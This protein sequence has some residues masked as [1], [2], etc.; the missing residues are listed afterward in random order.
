MNCPESIDNTPLTSPKSFNNWARSLN[1]SASQ[2]FRP[3]TRGEI[4]EIFRRAEA[5]RRKVKVIGSLWSFTSS[6][7]SNDIVIESDNISG[8]IDPNLIIGRL[9][10]SDV[11][12]GLLDRGMLAHI[13]GGTKVCKINRM[14][15][16][17]SA[18]GNCGGEDEDNLECFTDSKAMPTLGG[19]GGQSIAGLIST[20][21]HGGDIFLRPIADN[22]LAIHLIGPGGQEWWI[23]RPLS[24][25]TGT[26]TDTQTELQNMA[27]SNTEISREICQHIRVKKDN[28]FFNAVLVSVG[29]MGFMYSLVI[30]VEDSFKLRETR[31]REI[32]EIFR[33]NVSPTNFNSFIFRD[34][35]HHLS[36]LINPFRINE[37]H[38]CFV[39]RR[40]RITCETPN[41]RMETGGSDIFAM[42]CNQADVGHVITNILF[43]LSTQLALDIG[44]L[45]VEITL[46]TL[47]LG[48]F[49]FFIAD[50]IAQKHAEIALKTTMK[51]AIDGFIPYLS[52]RSGITVGALIAEISNFAYGNG[53]KVIIK[54]LLNFIFNSSYP[55]IPTDNPKVGVS[56]KIMDTYGYNGEDFCLKVDSMEFAFDVSIT[57]G[58]GYLGFI[59]EALNIFDDLFNR[60]I[61]VAGTL[62][63]RYT[64]NTE[65][66]LGMS[67]FPTTCHIEI[68]ILKDFSGNPE[69][70]SRIQ[71]AALRFNGVPHWGQLM[72]HYNSTDI[73]NLH[74]EDL[75]R[76]RNVLVELIR[77]GG[78]QDF[79]FS[80]NFTF[81]YNLEP[82]WE[83]AFVSCLIEVIEGFGRS[84]SPEGFER[85]RG[86]HMRR[87]RETI[88]QPSPFGRLIISFY[89]RISIIFAPLVKRSNIIRKLVWY[90]FVVPASWISQKM[91]DRKINEK[92]DKNAFLTTSAKA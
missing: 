37:G 73:R 71:S 17:L 50:K 78:G 59:Q 1:F 68:S 74:G 21:S 39:T 3:S 80:N 22:I 9:S 27:A 36:I 45:G 5:E 81:T 49:S 70:L 41:N 69:F 72:N 18:D 89:R 67:K 63:L 6:F 33:D 10:L 29:R 34:E 7:V 82:H 42:V 54:E 90:G 60:N 57:E 15:H 24:L 13:K 11:G 25:T 66:F 44:R 40:E 19:S 20:G 86:F 53:L 43:P 16:G 65:A 2:S 87:F 51:I 55:S 38:E 62:S 91:V 76:W 31:T 26:E 46:L 75:S 35:P 28:D 14:L 79:T 88:L 56:W 30:Q 83:E 4:V 32:W 12:R 85:W 77:S 61:P 48:P 64:R 8:V 52:T 58:G 92:T 47:T 84:G 23:E